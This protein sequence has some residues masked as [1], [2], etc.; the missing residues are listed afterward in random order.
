MPPL[1]SS[2]EELNAQENGD[3]GV[4]FYEIRNNH[5]VCLLGAGYVNLTTPRAP[6]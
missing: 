4:P 1:Q 5:E 3:M 6:S 2:L